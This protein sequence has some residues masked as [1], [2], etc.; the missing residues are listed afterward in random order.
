MKY[1][2]VP[3][4]RAILIKCTFIAQKK[5]HVSQMVQY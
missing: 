5:L 3:K 4:E 1:S 2:L